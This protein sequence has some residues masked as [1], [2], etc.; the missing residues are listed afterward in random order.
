LDETTWFI[1][2][3]DVLVGEVKQMVDE[4]TKGQFYSYHPDSFVPIV[5]Q[6]QTV[7][8]GLEVQASL[9]TYQ[10]DTSGMPLRLQD[11][12]G[13]TVWEAHYTAHGQIDWLDAHVP[14]QLRMQ[15]QYYDEESGLHYNRHRYY[16]PA[17]GCFISQ[18]PIGLEGGENPYRY[19][20]NVFGWVDPLGLKGEY[21]P[22]QIHS[23]GAPDIAKKGLHFY[24]P[25][26][27]ELSV[28]PDHRGGITFKAA[29]HGQARS[30]K[31]AAAIKMATERF[32]NNPAFRNDILAKARVGMKSV[33]NFATGSKRALANGRSRELRD[34]VKN[35]SRVIASLGG[36][37]L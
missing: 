28:R 31:V 24:A 13:E 36:C 37:G 4:S 34:I 27:A 26:G 15:G 1:W 21:L 7:R 5:M 22:W 32:A 25:N 11:E 30:P 29:L 10:N 16:D 20:P 23:P 19:A 6:R 12:D 35:V 9:L 2:D 14:Q 3:A 8:E 18:D 33:L 17:A